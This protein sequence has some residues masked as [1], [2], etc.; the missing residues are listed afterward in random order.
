MKANVA[1]VT[2]KQ[3]TDKLKQQSK[4]FSRCTPLFCKEAL[5]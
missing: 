4:L 3:L 5:G 2:A 1:N